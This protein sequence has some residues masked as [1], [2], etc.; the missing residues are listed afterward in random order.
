MKIIQAL[1]LTT[2]LLLSACTPQET[3]S[4]WHYDF[5]TSG[6][7]QA[8]IPLANDQSIAHIHPSE[9]NDHSVATIYDLEGKILEN[10][11]ISEDPSIFPAITNMATGKRYQVRTSE[12]EISYSKFSADLTLE[13]SWVIPRPKEIDSLT[14]HAVA[15]FEYSDNYSI[16]SVGYALYKIDENGRLETSLYND[17]KGTFYALGIDNNS[18]ILSRRD[19]TIEVYN[20]S[21]QLI[22]SFDINTTFYQHVH[23]VDGAIYTQSNQVLTKYSTLSGKK[24]WDITLANTIQ[25]IQPSVNGDSIYVA[26]SGIDWKPGEISSYTAFNKISSIGKIL[27][28]YDTLHSN[29]RSPKIHSVSDDN[30]LVSYEERSFEHS[31]AGIIGSGDGTGQFFKVNKTTH[32]QYH[33]LLDSNGNSKR[34]LTMDS[35]VKDVPICGFVTCLPPYVSEEGVSTTVGSLYLDNNIVLLSLSSESKKMTTS[36]T[37]ETIT[38]HS[39]TLA[40]Y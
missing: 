4:N 35:Y 5:E 6:I 1:A 20:S 12:T 17:Q 37:L 3:P 34:K 26:I 11:I 38:P 31:I 22:H 14:T 19:N 39:M 9:T 8:L 25:S 32:T 28:V 27:W 33:E 16:V 15:Q 40:L 2:V 29:A 24:M 10:K 30:V 21:L 13:W 36:F 23:Y 7:N 18:N